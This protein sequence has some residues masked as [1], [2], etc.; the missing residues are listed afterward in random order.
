[1][2]KRLA[3]VALMVL[4]F[5]F[6]NGNGREVQ[7]GIASYYAKSWTGRKTASGE[8]LHH[9]SLTCAHRKYPFGTKLRVTNPKNGK[10]VIVR[11]TDRGPYS[12]GRIIDLSWGAAKALDMLSKG[13]IRVE[14]EKYDE[15]IPPFLPDKI[16]EPISHYTPPTWDE[17][18][19]VMHDEADTIEINNVWPR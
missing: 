2:S 6:L 13:I 5:S 9:D 7:T 14:V 19:K 12:K 1:M 3:Y 16:N 8:L 15:I 4:L 18:M 10:V 11:V 17:M